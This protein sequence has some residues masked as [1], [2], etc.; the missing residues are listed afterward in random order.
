VEELKSCET[1]GKN[2]RQL[3][4]SMNLGQKMVA[5]KLG[6]TQLQYSRYETGRTN[7]PVGMLTPLARAFGISVSSLLEVIAETQNG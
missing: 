2:L 5:L 1:M 4:D 6:I 3:R 7:I